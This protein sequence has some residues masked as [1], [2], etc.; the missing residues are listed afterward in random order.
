MSHYTSA[1]NTAYAEVLELAGQGEEQ[2]ARLVFRDKMLELGHDE[3]IKNLYRVRDKLTAKATFFVP[4]APQARFLAGRS[5]RDMILKVR[6]VGFTTLSCVEALDY[7]LWEPNMVT[8]IMAHKQTLVLSIFN[9]I[10]KFSY[11]HFKKDWGHLY[12]PEQKTDSTTSL[13]FSNDGLGR[14]LNSIMT[15]KFDYRGQTPHFLHI[16][17]AAFV[18]DARLLGSV[19]G[20]PITGEVRFEST[21]NGMGGE[22]HRLWHLYKKKPASAPYKPFF[23]PWFEFYPEKPEMFESELPDDLTEYEALLMQQLGEQL[24]PEAIHWRRWCIEANCQGDAE[25]FEAEY[26]TNDVDCWISN[27]SGVF[28]KDIIKAQLKTV[29]DPIKEGY[30]VQDGA[31]TKLIEEPKGLVEIWDLPETNHTY[32]LG[33]DPAGGVGKDKSALYV[34]DQKTKK[35]VARIW[36]DIEPADFAKE[37][38]KISKYYN[39][40]WACIES[41]NHGGLVIH[42]LKE[43]GFSKFYKRKV[44]DELTNK[45][46]NKIGFLTTNDSKLRITEQLKNALRD[47][48]F[49]TQ[50]EGLIA[51]LSTFMQFASKNGRTIRREAQS[52][53]HDDL[54]IAACLTQEMDKVRGAVNASE[55]L[56]GNPFHGRGVQFDP[57]TGFL[58]S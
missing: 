46:T 34:K 5:R 48:D 36:A 13:S 17:E 16:A 26:P 39:S 27:Q 42:A 1:F 12:A 55:S 22:F 28:S 57:E 23:V 50:D 56:I 25:K 47:S 21:C 14:E 35:Q 3:R 29:R 19:N 51:E 54:V 24:T 52:N 58:I 18:E 40:A 30:L 44:L 9:D 43:M 31:T 2:S 38:F 33:A 15:V 20:V 32:V 4:N 7:V 6:Q 11:A 10:V 45:P 8:G 49:I 41:N 53:A 37:I